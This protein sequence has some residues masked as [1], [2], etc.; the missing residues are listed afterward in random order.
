[1]PKQSKKME[2]ILC[3]LTNS[4]LWGLPWNVV[5]TPGDSQLEE[6]DFSFPSN[7]Q[8]KITSWLGVGLYGLSLFSARILDWFDPVHVLCM[9]PQA[10]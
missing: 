2:F 9:L 5:G 8:L 10:P 7:D 4:R 1:M 6:T 3:W